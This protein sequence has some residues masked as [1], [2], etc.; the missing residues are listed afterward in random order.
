MQNLDDVNW[1]DT[2]AEG[3]SKTPGDRGDTSDAERDD[4]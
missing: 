4:E 3:F 1:L 2:P